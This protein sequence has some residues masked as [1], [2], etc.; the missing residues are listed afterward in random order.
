MGEPIPSRGPFRGISGRDPPPEVP[1][2]RSRQPWRRWRGAFLVVAGAL[3]LG[4]AALY[5][6]YT[7]DLQAINSRLMAESRVVQTSHGAV[8]YATAGDGP[9]ALV[10][11][12]A[13]GGYDQGL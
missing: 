7:R 13:G 6:T 2:V 11:H 3:A 9:P 10:L 4:T 1:I 8:E 12:G 5:L